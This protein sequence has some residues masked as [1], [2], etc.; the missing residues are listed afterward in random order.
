MPKNFLY[1][2]RNGLVILT[3]NRPE[4][5][6]FLSEE[7]TLEYERL[8]GEVREDKSARALIVTGSGNSFCAGAD[9]TATRG[10]S[11][12]EEIA[13]RFAPV[14]HVLGPSL[15]RSFDVVRNLA[16]PTICAVNG[17][18]IGGGWAIA[19]S[20]D[21]RVAAAGAEFWFPEV[22]LGAPMTGAIVHELLAHVG[23][24]ITREIT[25]NCRHYKAEELL[26]LGLV[27][28]VVKPPAA[29]LMGAALEAARKL[30]A[31][32]SAAVALSKAAITQWV[33]QASGRR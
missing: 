21:F 14:A 7:V 10:A 6:N 33:N 28:E 2:N 5:R 23:P 16:I 18:A 8:V 11:D 30:L 4:K 19:L 31:K 29:E 27:N 9:V 3:F 15:E 1:E 13:R 24:A 20:F 26:P 32:K 25:I 22:D 17:Y 12:P